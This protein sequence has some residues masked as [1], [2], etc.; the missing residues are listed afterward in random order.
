MQTVDLARQIQSKHRELRWHQRPC[1][2]FV[3]AP[4]DALEVDAPTLLPPR[5]VAQRRERD[6]KLRAP[7]VLVGHRP[8]PPDRAPVPVDETVGDLPVVLGPEGI[9]AKRDTRLLGAERVEDG[10]E[11]IGLHRIVRTGDRRRI[12]LVADDTHVERMLGE[13]HEHLGALGRRLA[14]VRLPLPEIGHR[15]QAAPGRVRR[16][17]A[18]DDG[19][20]HE[21]NR[22]A[23]G[24]RGHVGERDETGRGKQKRHASANN[25]RVRHRS[26]VREGKAAQSDRAAVSRQGPDRRTAAL[27]PLVD[28]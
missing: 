25:G 27:R 24:A 2:G 1:G 16:D 10:D 5:P 23:L 14:V 9:G 22:R 13:T 21:A 11:G 28:V 6:F 12:G 7:T 18:I 4:G 17:V 19:G 8:D 15:C 26:T 20:L 3:V